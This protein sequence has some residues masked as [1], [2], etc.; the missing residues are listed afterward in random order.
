MNARTLK[1]RSSQAVAHTPRGPLTLSPLLS[2]VVTAVVTWV[3]TAPAAV[4]DPDWQTLSSKKG[5]LAAP[6][7]GS[8]QQTGAVVGD[9]DGDGVKDFILSFR[10]KAPALV[11]YR[12][13]QTGWEQSVIEKQ[14][15]TVEAG[16][17]VY[18]IDGDGDQDVVFGGDWQSNEV[19]WWEN[20]APQFDP[21]T[22]WKRHLI[23]KGGKTQHH[24]QVFGD[25]LG[26]GQ[27]QLAF[28]SQGAKTI[29]LAEI[30]ENPR[31]AETWPMKAIYS[32]SA[33][34]EGRE[35][36]K[37]PE[38]IS[39]FDIDGD[40]TVDLLAGN[41][42]FKH[43]GDGRFKAIRIAEVGGLIFAGYF[44][45]SRYPQIV[46]SPGDAAGPLRWYECTGAPENP[47]DWTGHDLL[48][49][50]I[51]HGH[52]LQ[53]GDLNG[54]GHLDIFV[55]EMAQWHETQP[56]PDQ[57]GAT[58]WVFYGDGQGHFRRTEL[59]K[60][61]GWHE[62]RLCDLDGDGD[63]DLLNKPYTWEAPR[64]DVWLNGGTRAGGKGVGTGRGFAGP[65]GLELYSLRDIFAKNVPLGLQFT[66]NYGFVEIEF[67]GSY[68]MAPEKFRETVRQY[69]FKPVAAMWDY[70]LVANDPAKVV[71]EAKA[72]G[73]QYAGTAWI[74]HTGDFTAAQARQAAQVFN[75]LGEM[76]AKDGRRFFYHNHGYEFVQHGAG[77]LFDLLVAE[78]KPEWVSFEM[79]VFWV[80]HPGLDPVKLLN[81]YP[82]RWELMHLKDMRKGTPTG[83]LTG[84]TDVRNDVSLGSGQID[85]AAV[86]KA[87]QRVGVKHYF[88]ED[89]SPAVVEQLPVSLRFLES[90]P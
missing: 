26:K 58:A 34:E 73:V 8:T 67:G 80:V 25:F 81:Q 66:R 61:Q 42:W 57:P 3:V 75:R 33:G 88:I 69:G 17:A 51:V 4:P 60:G 52:S 59:A 15:L 56:Q 2:L 45:P 50:N 35:T 20:P 79:D 70:N 87:A 83:L 38:G 28:W 12:R 82:N 71:A 37:Y 89:E 19:W 32:G 65:V 29:F 53:L 31:Q 10:Q 77:T 78:T 16:G 11:W 84:N 44:K 6:P 49:R 23:K 30:P 46:I 24:D 55:A 22:S 62:A 47:K 43:L 90:L 36:F 85:L 41:T 40:G 72:F 27:P 14:Y 76:L 1:N 74:P 7:G 13:T 39:A 64:V 21:R 63:L 9:F 86:L 54:D 68:G 5:D 18:D 48:E